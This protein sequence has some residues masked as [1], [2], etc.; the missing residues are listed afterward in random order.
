MNAAPG[1]GLRV[2]RAII[3]SGAGVALPAANQMF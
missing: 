2:S 3:N 1:A